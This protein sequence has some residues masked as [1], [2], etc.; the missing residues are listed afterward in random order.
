MTYRPAR[1]INSNNIIYTTCDIIQRFWLKPTRITTKSKHNMKV[2][3]QPLK[4]N[5]HTHM[6]LKK[7]NMVTKQFTM[8][9]M[10]IIHIYT[11]IVMMAAKMRHRWLFWKYRALRNMHRIYKRYWNSI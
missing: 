7:P 2:F 4:F 1:N 6:K 3:E 10:I 8:M 9:T 11:I 5:H